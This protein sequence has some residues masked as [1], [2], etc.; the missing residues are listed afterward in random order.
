[1]ASMCRNY[2]CFVAIAS[3]VR[4]MSPHSRARNGSVCP[5]VRATQ[6]WRTP[7]GD[8]HTSAACPDV[9]FGEHP[10]GTPPAMSGVAFRGAAR[11]H[12]S[13]VSTVISASPCLRTTPSRNGGELNRLPRVP[14]NGCRS[15]SDLA[16]GVDLAAHSERPPELASDFLPT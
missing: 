10:L 2:S 1:M 15:V 9:P 11:R 5:C 8:D 13:E 3:I 12:A 4:W 16:F 7:E 14:V 6:A